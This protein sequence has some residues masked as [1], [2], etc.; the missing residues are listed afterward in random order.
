[1]L[2]I[3]GDAHPH[4]EFAPILPAIVAVLGKK[5]GPDDTLACVTAMIEGHS[6]PA[7][8][9]QDWAYF[10]LHRRDYL[11]FERVFEDLVGDFAPR[12]AK[13]LR[14]LQG[15]RADFVP[16][17]DRLLSNFF[18]GI[19]PRELTLRIFDC[20]LVEG[21]KI[22]LRFA[23]A[24]L[25]VRQDEIL[26]SSDPEGA[27]QA[28][29]HREE[30]PHASAQLIE[31]YFQWAFRV[32]FDR[33]IIQ[34]YR[35]RRRKHSMGDFDA[36]DKLLL[37]QR[38]LPHLS[39]PSSFM[40]DDNWASLWSWIPARYRLLD[41]H[42][43]FTTAEHGRHLATLY[44]RCSGREP[45]LL[46]VETMAGSIVGVYISKAL[47]TSHGPRFYGSGETF[48]FSLK[49]RIARHPWRVASGS[50]AFICATEAFLAFGE[51]ASDFGLWLDRPM[52]RITSSASATFG[53]E[54]L[55]NAKDPNDLLVYCAEVFSFV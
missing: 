48:I 17:W 36:E 47:T 49:P 12:L 26:Q 32:K 29:L 6:I 30:V 25:L 50:L 45:L 5:L 4:L 23:I 53:N 51:G 39:R 52:S 43:A 18:I 2:C 34:R 14:R 11:V 19:L 10:P 8:K 44:E 1:M 27:T 28:I 24:H 15:E 41:L 3:L 40:T 42:L 31:N 22:I 35:N 13:H 54:P 20:Y 37:F 9:R 21:Y 46:L 7:Y 55:V 33:S 38:P 16:P